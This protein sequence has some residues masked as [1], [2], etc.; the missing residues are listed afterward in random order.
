MALDKDLEGWM[1]LGTVMQAYQKRTLYAL[2]WLR[3]LAIKSK[4]RF[5]VRLVKGAYWDYEIKHAQVEGL[6]GYPV[7]TQKVNTDVSYIA[8]AK[9]MLG[10]PEQ[11]Y[12]QF[13]THNAYSLSAILEIAGVYK[14]FEFQCLHGMGDTLY[15]Q[16]LSLI[17]I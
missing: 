12:C 9:L 13:A 7:F 6:A 14:D 11:F 1:G 10:N 16:V 15:D 2:E 3:K 5:M 8:C 17:H 4:R